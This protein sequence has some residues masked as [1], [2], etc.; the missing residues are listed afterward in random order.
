[1]PYP[2]EHSARIKEPDAFERIR[3]L[4][5]KESQGIRAIGGPLKS[6]PKGGTEVQAIRFKVDKWTAAKAKAWLKSHDYKVIQF[7]PAAGEKTE[8]EKADDEKRAESDKA[9][10]E[11][12]CAA[13]AVVVNVNTEP[14]ESE[15]DDGEP[16]ET[17]AECAKEHG[18]EI[19]ELLKG[20]GWETE[21]T[22]DLNEAKKIAM[23]HL[24][25]N[26]TYYTD[27]EKA[28]MDKKEKEPAANGTSY[29]FEIPQIKTRK[30]PLYAFAMPMEAE[31]KSN[32]EDAR[33]ARVTLQALSG[34][35]LEH[36]F[37]GK[38][39][40]DL[41]G[42]TH[43]DKIALDYMHNPNE[44]VGY[45]NNFDTSNG[46]LTVSGALVPQKTHKRVEEII[47]NIHAGIPYEASIYFPP[48]H[49]G[50]MEIEE[51]E[52]DDEV[53]V[54]GQKYTGP[55]T[56]FRRWSLRGCA[57][58]P[59]GMDATTHAFLQANDMKKEIEISVIKTKERKSN[60]DKNKD[61]K[62]VELTTQAAPVVPVIPDPVA[63]P[64]PTPQEIFRQYVTEFGELQAAKY[65][66]EGLTMEKAKDKHRQALAVENAELRTKLAE[67]EQA[68]LKSKP[69]IPFDP[70]GG[71]AGQAGKYGL[72]AD[73]EKGLKDYAKH[74]RGVDIEKLR[75]SMIDANKQRA[76]RE[77]E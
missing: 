12:Q 76:E 42:M 31:I 61:P 20:I 8:K 59:H 51:V 64:A 22:S 32:G 48:S 6:N 69:V 35:V 1:M 39:I 68:A 27:M 17:L 19:D 23:D 53:E 56:I 73:Q 33:S 49:P 67:A 11:R 2:N 58:C 77:N 3:E 41:A 28:G 66:A 26:P 44:L 74:S 14:V 5:R 57:V 43:R 62:P 40:Q 60:M 30:V 71:Q 16:D 13:P 4:W 72:T 75:Q 34:K 52:D 21:H 24:K 36:P 29:S 9:R 7:E 54:N 47:E 65:F 70:A 25:E 15:E 55:L 18:I 46:T 38:V 37:F 50:D 63:T 45:A 10:N